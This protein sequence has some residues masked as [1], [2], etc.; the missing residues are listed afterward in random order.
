M[1]AE[2][3]REIGRGADERV[4]QA[5]S[6]C[7]DVRL[8]RRHADRGDDGAAAIVHRS[9]ERL[10]PRLGIAFDAR[11]AEAPR[12]REIGPQAGLAL[13]AREPTSVLALLGTGEIREARGTGMQRIA[14]PDSHRR[15][16]TTELATLEDEERFLDRREQGHG[17]ANLRPETVEDRSTSSH[18]GMLLDC[19]GPELEHAKT[20]PDLLGSFDS[21]E[22]A[23]FR[24]R[25]D[26]AAHGALVESDPPRE[27]HD[28]ELG[29]FVAERQEKTMRLREGGVPI[30]GGTRFHVSAGSGSARVGELPDVIAIRKS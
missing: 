9:G 6:R 11:V 23:D 29:G 30:R 25:R 8:R 15:Q 22:E 20:E 1:K 28:A 2:S 27:I 19:E 5:S 18:E 12:S 26:E 10:Q 7:R 24:Q 13:A 17:L 4:A 21:L 16:G 14:P 3:T